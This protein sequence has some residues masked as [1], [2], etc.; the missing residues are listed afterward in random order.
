[1]I[2][3]KF[4]YRDIFR[5]PR[6]AFSLQKMWIQLLGMGLGYL[7]YLVFSYLSLL[8]AGF[9]FQIAWQQYGLLPCLFA[10]GESVPWYSWLLAGI[11]CLLL[12]LS[13]L[14]TNT[15]V[16]RAIYMS[17]KGNP[18]YTWKESFAF[19]FRKKVSIILTPLSLVALIGLM[20]LGAFILGLLGKIPFIGPLGI[21][22]FTVIWFFMSLVLLF[23]AIVSIVATILVPSILATT[24]EDAFE[25]IFQSF[26]IAWSQPWRLIFYEAMTIILSL[27]AMGV[28]AL[29]VKQ[30]T[31]IMNGLFTSFMGSQFANLA[32]NGQAMVQGWTLGAQNI[33]NILYQ[34]C[35]PMLFFN[36]V[37]MLIPAADLSISVVISSYLYALS[38]LFIA[39]W[40]LSYGLS[41]FTAG[42]TLLFVIIKQKKDEENLLERK[43][44][45]EEEEEE[46]LLTDEEKPA[47]EVASEEKDEKESDDEKNNSE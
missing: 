45:E 11:A 9:Q 24:D 46:E 41:T 26:S 35:A 17:S 22:L 15:A 42:N 30:A 19:A 21:S 47:E 39:G 33:V 31:V 34:N 44:K 5:A 36:N 32:N 18:F 13:F 12:I 2:K 28:F 6:M 37:F 43:D 14:Y 8:A 25:A 27:F 3:L 38:L 1:M 29:F 23:F 4:D 7:L 20:I 16:S 40:V 10:T